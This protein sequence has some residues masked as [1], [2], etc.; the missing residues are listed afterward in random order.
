MA[1]HKSN[2]GSYGSGLPCSMSGYVPEAGDTFGRPGAGCTFSWTDFDV[3][4]DPDDPE[5]VEYYEEE[6]WPEFRNAAVQ[7]TEA[8][9]AALAEWQ[10]AN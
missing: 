10:A 5:S 6:W 9:E 1:F 7:A 8:A 3:G 2:L 4:L